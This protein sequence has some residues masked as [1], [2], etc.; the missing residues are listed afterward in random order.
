MTDAGDT[1]PDS[2]RS[3][4]WYRDRWE[5][6]QEIL[7]TED[8]ARVLDRVRTLQDGGVPQTLRD[9]HQALQILQQ[10]LGTNT[11]ATT[12]DMVV[13]LIDEV[14]TLRSFKQTF[15]DAGFQSPR[16]ALEILDR[17]ETEL[18][19][20]AGQGDTESLGEP[21]A[22][23]DT[24]APADTEDDG[25]L[26]ARSAL[27]AR[28]ET[29]QDVLG[30]SDPDEVVT[31]VQDLVRQLEELYASRERLAQADLEDADHALLMIENME[32]Q[33]LDLY[34]D[35]EAPAASA[36]AHPEG[37]V[38]PEMRTRLDDLSASDLDALD[39]GA[40]RVDDDGRIQS[41]NEAALQWPGLEAP[42]T[43]AVEGANFFFDVAPGTNS[44]VF[45]DRF[46][47]AVQTGET[48]VSFPYTYVSP[49]APLTTLTVHLYRSAPDQPTWIL[50]R[51][52]DLEPTAT[53]PSAGDG[54]PSQAS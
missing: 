6:L 29:L 37:I 30:V 24:E 26:D 23:A 44:R 34:Q 52:S 7:S 4:A 42:T 39:A 3:P 36:E 35:R 19:R 21:A 28:E 27:R 8:P 47:Q 25:E 32:K 46:D 11:I 2:T 50:F 31:M 18:D 13:G 49:E 43:A 10:R 38:A 1:A 54:E 5:E 15:D 17:M 16:Q 51:S 12:V 53:G 41:A 33:L 40:F 45:R 22:S 48:D 20:T 9:A 14:R